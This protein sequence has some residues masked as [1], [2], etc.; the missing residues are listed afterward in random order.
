MNANINY[1]IGQCYINIR[2][3]KLRS[4]P[5]LERASKNI[6]AQ[7]IE[8]EFE[9]DVASLEALF[10]L[11]ESYQ[12]NNQLDKA[13]QTFL[14]YKD[15]LQPKDSKNIDKA[16][17]KIHSISIAKQEI[18]NP[19][20]IRFL[21]LGSNIN[22]RFSDYN[23]VVSGDQNLLVFTSFWESA[24][25]ILQSNYIDGEWSEPVNITEELGSEGDCYTGAISNDGMQLYLIKQGNYNSDIYVSYNKDNRWT[26]MQKLNKRINSNDQE[27]SISISTDGN[28]IYFSSNRPGG[29][30]GFDIY[31]SEKDNGEWC[32]PVNLGTVINASYSEDGPGIWSEW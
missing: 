10:L 19:V 2:G 24:D 7:Y 29:E 20:D 8:G 4:I 18:N 26:P 14:D 23:P 5:Y 32:K 11:G 30:G 6:S 16:E 17:N 28:T 3:E 12:R 9:S 21:N 13:L 25:L 1:R 31:K 15:L 27:T 22:S